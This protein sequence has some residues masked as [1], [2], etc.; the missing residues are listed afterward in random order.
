[1][2]YAAFLFLSIVPLG[3]MV[4]GLAVTAGWMRLP[5]ALDGPQMIEGGAAVGLMVFL[6]VL[7]MV[8]MGLL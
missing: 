1:M 7:N 6:F 4:V 8:L 2:L 3:A 5:V